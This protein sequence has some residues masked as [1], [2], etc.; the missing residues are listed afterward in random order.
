MLRY[1]PAP[2]RGT[3]AAALL[4]CN[5]LVLCWPLFIGAL[6][7]FALPFPA[8]GRRINR[9]MHWS[10]EAW[11]AFNKWWMDA[12]GRTRWDVQGLQSIRLDHSYL[13]TSNHQS[14]VDIL[15]LQYLLNRRAPFLKF[16]LKQQLIW[17]PVIGLCW[18]ALEFPFMKRFS[19]EY[20]E[21]HPEK[22]GQDMLT[23]RKACERYRNHA[24]SVFNFLEG[25][26]NTPSK[27]AAQNSP[28]RYLL[29]PRAGGIAFVLD[30][31][32]AQ[33][34][35]L[36]NV[37]IHYPD[38]TPTFWELLCGKIPRIVVRF[39]QIAIPVQFTGRSYE[40]DE[41]YRLE[42]QQWVNKLWED[43]DSLLHE[44]HAAYPPGR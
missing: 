15:V 6:F 33:M 10:A 22:R 39:E 20:L 2:L 27:H 38:G 8:A 44:L 42:F 37:T 32:G 5:T 9:L 25:T 11:I 12:V 1:L 7:K 26:R 29:R 23:T 18:W 16:F 19:R 24:V 30:A 35:S 14:S 21:R 36:L 34:A 43:K 40:Q 17:V 3:I 4:V 41:D 13:V 28:F 31:M